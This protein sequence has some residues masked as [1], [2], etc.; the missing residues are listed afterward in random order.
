MS[1]AECAAD[2]LARSLKLH[3]RPASAFESRRRPLT[4][5]RADPVR[6]VRQRHISTGGGACTD[7]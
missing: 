6:L 5:R 2:R 1:S 7:Q 4:L 3:P